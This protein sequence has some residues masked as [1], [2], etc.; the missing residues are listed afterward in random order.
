MKKLTGG[1]DHEVKFV[2]KLLNNFEIDKPPSFS[3]ITPEG[4][5]QEHT[6]NMIS[7]PKNQI[8]C[9]TAGEFQ[10]PQNGCECAE[11][12]F[13]MQGTGVNWKFGMVVI[14]AVVVPKFKIKP[15]YW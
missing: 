2:L 15:V 12:K 7:M 3:L 1:M 11:I 13:I 5:K 8:I 6:E 14:G 4:C 10:T 9:I